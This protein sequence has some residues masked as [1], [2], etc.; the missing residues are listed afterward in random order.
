MH[1]E[2][3][4]INVKRTELYC[5]SIPLGKRILILEH[6]ANEFLQHDICPIMITGPCNL[7]PFASHFYIIKLWFTGV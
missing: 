6:L 2:L 7:Y 5:L 3:E 4:V 1:V